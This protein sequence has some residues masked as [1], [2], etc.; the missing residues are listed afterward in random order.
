MFR[1]FYFYIWLLFSE[2]SGYSAEKMDPFMLFNPSPSARFFD[3]FFLRLVDLGE[4]SSMTPF[5]SLP[6]F[7]V[8]TVVSSGT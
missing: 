1:E 7:G 5:F 2:F 8:S 6:L 4:N 3:R